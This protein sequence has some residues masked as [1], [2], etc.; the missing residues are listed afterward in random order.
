MLAKCPCLTGV[1]HIPVLHCKYAGGI[2]LDFGVSSVVFSGDTIP[3][4]QIIA[5]SRGCS[6]LI[7]EATFGSDRSAE[8]RAKRHS[9]VEEAIQVARESKSKILILT[10]FS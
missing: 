8:A 7:H 10:H 4:K 1:Q 6:V 2:R 3:C 5:A 9:T